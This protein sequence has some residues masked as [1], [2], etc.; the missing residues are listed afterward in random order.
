MQFPIQLN[1]LRKQAPQ[2]TASQCAIFKSI[3]ERCTA[4]TEYIYT[5][6][7]WCMRAIATSKH[8]KRA[9]CEYVCPISISLCRRLAI[10][11]SCVLWLVECSIARARMCIG[12]AKP[13]RIQPICVFYMCV[14]CA[15]I[16]DQCALRGGGC[17]RARLSSRGQAPN[18]CKHTIGIHW[19]P[20]TDTPP[21]TDMCINPT[22]T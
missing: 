9:V 13:P 22:H 4:C 5:C 10:Y 12:L 14:V 1:K 21:C 15:L 7:C 2:K 20:K 16:L 8:T 3:L 18:R 17:S 6:I 19:M 11:L